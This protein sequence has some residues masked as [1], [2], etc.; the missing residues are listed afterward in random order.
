MNA[1]LMTNLLK[2]FLNAF[3][4]ILNMLLESTIKASTEIA[5]GE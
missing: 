5:K 3:F 4:N 2:L 1:N